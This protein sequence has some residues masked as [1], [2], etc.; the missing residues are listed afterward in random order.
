[1]VEKATVQRSG[2]ATEKALVV[3]A[4]TI[5]VA[6]RMNSVLF[7]LDGIQLLRTLS[8]EGFIPPEVPVGAGVAGAEARKGETRI[9]FDAEKMVIAAIA[10]N[11]RD[12]V[13]QMEWLEKL[14]K[15]EFGVNTE[16]MAQYYELVS[17][18][19]VKARRSPLDIWSSIAPSIPVLTTLSDALGRPLAPFGLRLFGSGQEPNSTDWFEV[20]IEP[21][22]PNSSS[23]HF[24]QIIFRNPARQA[25]FDYTRRLEETVSRLFTLLE[26]A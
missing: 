9:R 4:S 24:F 7:P 1:M 15:A 19:L 3:A 13:E 14:V 25:V 12:A 22:L 6:E 18:M 8:K 26:E 11:P 2:R 5:Q 17:T 16:S 10:S 23:Q 20:R 21:Q